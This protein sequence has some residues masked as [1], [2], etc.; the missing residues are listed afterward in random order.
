MCY[1]TFRYMN[2]KKYYLQVNASS[3]KEQVPGQIR[4]RIWIGALPWIARGK[5]LG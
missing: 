4:Q 3:G 1:A 5:S 2:E